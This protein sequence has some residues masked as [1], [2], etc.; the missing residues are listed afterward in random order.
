MKPPQ[1]PIQFNGPVQFNEPVQ[2]HE[3]VEFNGPVQF[4]IHNQGS[5]PPRLQ[6][7]NSLGDDLLL[8]SADVDWDDDLILALEDDEDWV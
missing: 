7:S 3:P 6:G 5:S 4:N 1:K 8:A 2:F